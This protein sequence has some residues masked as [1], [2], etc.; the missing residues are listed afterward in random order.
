MV[1]CYLSLTL[2]LLCF[3]I[4]APLCLV[5]KIEKFSITHIFADALILITTIVILI[6]A[7]IHLKDDGWG[8]GVVALNTSTWLDMIGSAVYSYEGIGVVLPLLEVTQKPEMYPR[9]LFYVLLTVMLLY[10]SF[11]EYCLFIYGDLLQTPLITDNL[12][13][14]GIVVYL[15]KILFS[16]NLVFTYPL[17]LHPA[18]T[19]I[20]S[21]LFRG[22]NKSPK[23]MWLKNLSRTILVLFT[24]IFCLSLG[25]SLDKFISVLG[26]LACTPIS[27]TLPCIFH[28]KL[29]ANEL[30]PRQRYI[31]YAIIALS[32]FIM[33]FCTGFTLWNWNA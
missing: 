13:K 20:E 10:V 32:L 27:F 16:I 9:I 8:T 18:S 5:R 12:P 21:Y 15:I 24:V 17:Q 29:F 23:R 33:V 31:D 3:I 19:I 26:S 14:E 22:M 6:Y 7:S 25:N 30:T 1:R 2:G 11:G 28:L 4:Y